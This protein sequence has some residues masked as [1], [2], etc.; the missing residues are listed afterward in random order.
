MLYDWIMIYLKLCIT[1]L[2]I[3]GAFFILSW[4]PIPIT[5][6]IL[7]CGALMGLLVIVKEKGY[8]KILVPG[9]LWLVAIGLFAYGFFANLPGFEPLNWIVYGA[10]VAAAANVSTIVLMFIGQTSIK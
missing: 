5:Y 7:P 4:D 9:I 6:A 1:V 3:V 8:R 10:F 2:I